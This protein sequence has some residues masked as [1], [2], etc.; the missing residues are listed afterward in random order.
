[1][2]SNNWADASGT[3]KK[4]SSFV[5]DKTKNSSPHI[6]V[7]GLGN[8]L[9]SDEGAGI[10]AFE[11]LLARYIIPDTVEV[12]DGGTMGMEL[13]SYF[14]GKRHVIII[15]AVDA[16][17][18][19]GTVTRVEN[20]PA[21]FQNKISPHQIGLIDILALLTLEKV[22]PPNVV[23]FG[24]EP[25]NINTGLE[26][27]LDVKNKIDYLLSKVV[28][29]LSYMGIELQLKNATPADYPAPS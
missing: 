11:K 19:T 12:I 26:M 7:M 22:T 1:M 15:D 5:S 2:S 18:P 17:Y 28:E 9:L 16:G 3:S 29:E 23:L 14:D 6:L 20:L 8:I 4:N 10:K 13:I 24:I 21:F 25:G 27:S